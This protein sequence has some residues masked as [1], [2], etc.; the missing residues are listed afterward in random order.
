MPDGPIAGTLDTYSH[1]LPN[2]QDQAAGV[3]EDAEAL[4]MMPGLSSVYMKSGSF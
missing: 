2:M 3:M 4:D 1:V